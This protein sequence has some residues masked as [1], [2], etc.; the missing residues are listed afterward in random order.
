[1]A[2]PQGRKKPK[3]G[4]KQYPQQ[5]EERVFRKDDIYEAEDSDPEEENDAHQRYDV[6]LYTLT[7]KN[8]HALHLGSEMHDNYTFHDACILNFPHI[9]LQRVD[10]YE[11]ELP[12]DF[13]DEEI[14]EDEAFNSEDERK[15]GH[16]FAKRKRGDRGGDDDHG[17][18]DEDDDDDAAREDDLLDSEEEEGESD[19][20]SELDDVFANAHDGDNADEDTDEDDEQRQRYEE[21]RND[22]DD[23][24][25]RQAMV[26]TL[27]G[28]KSKDRRNHLHDTVTTEVYPESEFNLPA[29][30]TFG[31]HAYRKIKKSEYFSLAE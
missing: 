3:G 14:D 2:K 24:D 4:R 31:I 16:L 13:E 21:A 23:D 18:D 7:T 30:G 20:G 27:T 26:D 12:S 15:Y 25:A 8:L 29:S 10:N 1:M 11:Y 6:R 28:R 5:R 17:S 9:P 19:S 22:D